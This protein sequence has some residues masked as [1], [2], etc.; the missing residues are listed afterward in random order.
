M[1]L[2]IYGETLSIVSHSASGIVFK[3]LCASNRDARVTI[4]ITDLDSSPNDDLKLVLNE[5]AYTK[6]LRH[7]N[8]MNILDC[9]VE[10]SQLWCIYPYIT[11]RAR[12]FWI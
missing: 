12:T 5:I 1:Y 3:R 9:F 11:A 4:R 2:S 6:G 10:Q 7:V 8:I